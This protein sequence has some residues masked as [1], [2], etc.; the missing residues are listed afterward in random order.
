MKFCKTLGCSNAG[1][2][3][4]AHCSCSPSVT[5]AANS[6]NASRTRKISSAAGGLMHRI[7]NVM[8]KFRSLTDKAFQISECNLSKEIEF[9]K[10]SLLPVHSPLN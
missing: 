6:A 8:E 10:A 9:Y 3:G 4:A 7:G 1:V 5:R 2:L